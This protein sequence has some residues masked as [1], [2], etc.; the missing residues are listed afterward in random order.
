M[1]GSN[2]EQATGLLS[3]FVYYLTG[4][5]NKRCVSCMC[6]SDNHLLD[7]HCQN[8]KLHAYML[9]CLRQSMPSQKVLQL[10]QL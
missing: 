7:E 3:F 8:L 2:Q 4:H 9:F 10:L 6:T 5:K 1:R